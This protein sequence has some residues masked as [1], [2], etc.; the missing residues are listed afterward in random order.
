MRGAPET[1]LVRILHHIYL[2][3]TADSLFFGV[4]FSLDLATDVSYF[5]AYFGADNMG[6]TMN[7]PIEWLFRC[8]FFRS[9][10]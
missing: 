7:L 2:N 4:A 8:R 10:F 9:L 3:W 1:L 6:F 5:G